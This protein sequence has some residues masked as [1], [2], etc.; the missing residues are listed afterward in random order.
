MGGPPIFCALVLV[1]RGWGASVLR[2]AIFYD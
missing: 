2:V 1:G